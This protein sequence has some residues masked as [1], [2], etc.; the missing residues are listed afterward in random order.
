MLVF[1]FKIYGKRQQFDA[2]DQA[3]RTVQFIQNKAI[4]LWMDGEKIGKNDLSKYCALLAKEFSFCDELN[5]MARQAS[6]ERSWSAI[7]RFYDNC[8]KKVP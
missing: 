4:R 3:I 6:A 5:S 2:V 1:E 8:K 7:S